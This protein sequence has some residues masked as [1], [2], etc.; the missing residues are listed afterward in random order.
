MIA[1]RFNVDI[2]YL[3]LILGLILTNA[4]FYSSIEVLKKTTTTLE[5]NVERIEKKLYD[6]K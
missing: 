3:S 4:N 6:L 5:S 2:K 1:S